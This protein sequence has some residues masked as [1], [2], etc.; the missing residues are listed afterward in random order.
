MIDDK[1]YFD[2]AIYSHKDYQFEFLP[3]YEI[4]KDIVK[5]GC[6]GD[7]LDIGCGEG[8]TALELARKG[9]NVTCIDISKT[10]INHITHKALEEGI[11]IHAICSDI[12]RFN[13]EKTYN[14]ILACGVLHFMT[15]KGVYNLLSNMKMKTAK[16]GLN[17]IE[18]FLE[19]DSSQEFDS[20]G[21]YFKKGELKRIY[22]N[23]NILHY[24]EYEDFNP[25]RCEKNL[26]VKIIAVNL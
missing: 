4:I 1:Y 6:L 2:N 19:G 7:I 25:K 21:H 18:A 17:L 13:I 26:L 10:A 3:N 24:E 11:P 22:S 16:G 5:Y 20:K 8:G 9:Y 12:E 23:W 15:R 14:T